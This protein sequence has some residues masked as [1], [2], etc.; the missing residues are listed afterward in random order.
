ME[1]WRVNERNQLD[2]IEGPQ[3]SAQLQTD[4]WSEIKCRQIRRS[5]PRTR[6]MTKQEE[7]K[8]CRSQCHHLQK[9]ATILTFDIWVPESFPGIL[10][11]FKG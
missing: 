11:L 7:N 5:R 4:E 3:R 9:G 6:L 1:K 10:W 8:A 2:S